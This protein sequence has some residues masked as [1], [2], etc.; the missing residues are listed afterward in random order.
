MSQAAR[1]TEWRRLVRAG[2]TVWAFPSE[3]ADFGNGRFM[4]L[5]T[6][7][8]KDGPEGRLIAAD[9]A[10]ALDAARTSAQQSPDFS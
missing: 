10:E 4:M 1:V 8:G 3:P 7:E 5:E 6:R 2:G 9:S